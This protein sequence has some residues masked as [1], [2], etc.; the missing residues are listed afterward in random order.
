MTGNARFASDS[1]PQSGMC[2]GTVGVWPRPAR[3]AHPSVR[4]LLGLLDC[5]I[6]SS[7]HIDTIYKDVRPLFQVGTCTPWPQIGD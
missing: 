3:P 2:A 6:T 7:T 4:T 1:M 5:A